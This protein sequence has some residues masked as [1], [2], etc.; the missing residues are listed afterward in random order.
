MHGIVLALK[1]LYNNLPSTEGILV[2]ECDC[3]RKTL[4]DV[5]SDVVNGGYKL[6]SSLRHIA[7]GD[8]TIFPTLFQTL[9]PIAWLCVSSDG[10]RM[11]LVPAM[12]SLLYRPPFSVFEIPR[13]R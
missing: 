7:H 13:N 5:K 11:R 9:L 3:F 8:V 2:T 1:R 10:V 6:L 12:E 4:M